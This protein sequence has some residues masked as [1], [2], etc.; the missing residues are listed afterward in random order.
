MNLQ[1][2]SDE[3]LDQ[4]TLESVKAE[5]KST[6]RVLHHLREVDKRRL[7]SKLKFKSLVDYAENRLG[8]PY[9]QAWRR[10][11]AMRLLKE[12][13]EIEEKIADGTLNLTNIGYS[14]RF[15]IRSKEI[16]S[17]LQGAEARVPFAN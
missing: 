17:A 10:I 12:M 9:D 8:Y 15:Q 7:F 11:E 1:N 16:D 4:Q 5:T 3:K 13:P 6:L 2:L 14:G